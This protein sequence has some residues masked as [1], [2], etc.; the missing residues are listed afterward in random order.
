MEPW[1]K[2]VVVE[3]LKI[4]VTAKAAKAVMHTLSS[5]PHRVDRN[6]M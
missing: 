4:R 2:L 1:A 6:A 5:V 3:V